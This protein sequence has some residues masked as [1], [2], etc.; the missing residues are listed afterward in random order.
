MNPRLQ[1]PRTCPFESVSTRDLN[2]NIISVCCVHFEDQ[3]TSGEKTLWNHHFSG[4]GPN[5]HVSHSSANFE[6][7]VQAE[8][9]R[10]ACMAVTFTYSY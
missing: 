10:S 7:M 8:P 4:Q 5:L 1:H 6:K 9:R 2:H 3:T